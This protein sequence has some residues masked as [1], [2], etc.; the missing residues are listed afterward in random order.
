MNSTIHTIRRHQSLL[1][2]LG[3]LGILLG[4]FA[5]R[6]YRLDFQELRGDEAFGYFF[7]QRT[8]DDIVRA[9]IAL[10]EPHP[11]ASYFVQK[12]WLGAAGDTEFALRFPGAWWGVLAVALLHRLARRLGYTR[13]SSVIAALLLALSPYAVWHAQ[14]ARMYAMSLALTLGAV[15][16]GLEALARRTWR[17][18]V[19]YILLALLALH[20]HYFA[21]FVLLALNLFVLLWMEFARR[22]RPMFVQWLL[23]QVLVLALYLPWL[24]GAGSILSG[25]GG[26]GDSPGLFG[27]LRRAFTV[28]AVGESAPLTWQPLWLLAGGVLLLLGIVRLAL[29]SHRDLRNL[30]LLVL[31]LGVPLL[32]T[33]WS[34][35]SRPIFNERYLV[36]ALPPFYL[37]IAAAFT[38]WP[39]PRRLALALPFA[40]ALLGGVLSVALALS[41]LRSYTDPAL[42]KTRG[43]REL[44]GAI[45]RLSAGLPPERVRV[46]QNFPDPT[47]WYYY[48]GEVA[49]LALPPGANDA[50]GARSRAQA[51]AGEGVQRV[52][53]PVQPAANWD[54]TG[55]ANMALDGWFDRAAQMQ[56]GVWPLQ[57]YAQPGA[58][59]TPVNTQFGAD[60]MLRGY[61]AVPDV[62]TPGGLLTAHIDWGQFAA[63]DGPGHAT[64]PA[65]DP[66]AGDDPRKVFV[67][68]LDAGGQLVAQDDRPLIFTGPR[69]SGSGLAVYGLLLP[70]ELGEGPY[71]LIAGV[72]DPTQEG[73][74][75]LKTPAGADHVILRQ[76]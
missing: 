22:M 46:A 10:A 70:S 39:L 53:L 48:R 75:R 65:R 9:T 30:L 27:A 67:Q 44:A 60:V 8:Y 13:L 73:A 2:R 32:A 11:V 37:L 61:V 17:W 29:G 71:R 68:L 42:S 12:A 6:L 24:L 62:L 25:Y 28:F 21:V 26:N 66:A 49:H 76:Y 41:L 18:A 23:W 40:V 50:A 34:A 56:E 35:Q 43:W 45:D 74:P 69:A 31:Y 20:T 57:I 7:S 19:A 64:S 36:A 54:A 47:L 5:L 58:A 33:W 1:L 3:L 15:V 16:C 63:N 51:L 52:I 14:D 59:L 72:Y 55:L 38:P 4:A